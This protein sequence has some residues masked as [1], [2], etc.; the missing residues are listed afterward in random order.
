MFTNVVQGMHNAAGV[1]A[2]TATDTLK[3]LSDNKGVLIDTRSPDAQKVSMVKGALTAEQFSA[4]VAS[5][6][7][8]P[9]GV[10]V[11]AHCWLG[12]ASCNFAARNKSK[13]KEQGFEDVKSVRCGTI[14]LVVAGGTLL[15]SSGAETKTVHQY[16]DLKGTFPSGYTE[17]FS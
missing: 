6:E 5:G 16:P 10:T 9:A 3:A 11:Y 12:G 14:G 4:K 15:D 17:K 7:I 13:L 8:K 1:E 2:A